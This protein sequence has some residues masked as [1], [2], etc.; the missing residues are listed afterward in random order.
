[1]SNK[2]ENTGTLQREDMVLSTR[3]RLARNFENAAFPNRL[4][5]QQ[6]GEVVNRAALAIAKSPMSNDF[7][8][9]FLKNNSPTD[10]SALVEKHLISPDLVKHAE[11]GALLLSN[12]KKVSIMVCEEDHLRIQAIMSGCQ[13]AKAYSVA[14]QVDDYIAENDSYAF[15]AK[16]G[17]LTACPTNVGTGLRASFMLHLP[18]LT[19]LNQIEAISQAVGRLGMT[20]RGFY[21]EGSHAFGSIY[22]I[23]NQI[24]LG[25]SE[26]DIMHAL[27]ETTMQVIDKE[28]A[29]REA[30]LKN[31]EVAVKDKL[32]RAQGILL[33]AYKLTSQELLQ[34][35]SDLR[36]G[37]G[38]GVISGVSA[39]KADSLLSLQPAALSQKAGKEMTNSQRDI[40]RAECV[41]LILAEE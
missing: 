29:A 24:T 17:F 16:Y 19:M 33:H 4:S 18:A 39:K 6:A 9:I 1:M 26:E 7:S 40:F 20:V 11:R 36:L 5:V 32:M 22:Q 2:S 41:K 37:V 30:L 3:V 23:S 14:S 35:W 13:L 28:I 38:T 21:G 31:S 10:N 12:D 15:S 27:E 25:R 34:L 8:L